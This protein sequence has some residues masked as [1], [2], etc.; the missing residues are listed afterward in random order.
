MDTFGGHEALLDLFLSRLRGFLAPYGFEVGGNDLMAVACRPAGERTQMFVLS[1]G[2]YR[3]PGTVNVRFGFEAYDTSR[4]I[5]PVVG[6]DQLPPGDEFGEI[7][8]KV[9]DLIY[10]WPEVQAPEA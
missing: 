9:R 2:S 6:H 8:A 7:F 5:I 3:D 10:D 1:Y 4:S